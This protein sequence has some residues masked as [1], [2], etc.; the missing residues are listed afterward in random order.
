MIF[1]IISAKG[2]PG[3]CVPYVNDGIIPKFNFYSKNCGAGQY[4]FLETDT[5]FLILNR[6][7]RYIYFAEFCV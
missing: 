3:S 6:Y 1:Y 4:W 2:I 5:I 7:F